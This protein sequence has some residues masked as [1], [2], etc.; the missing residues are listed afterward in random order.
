MRDSTKKPLSVKLRKSKHTMK[1]AKMA[2]KY[3]DAIAIHPRTQSQ[4]Y[5][6]VPDIE[7]A[8]R[9]KK[10]SKVPVIYSG[11][12]NL[13]NH[14]ELLK[15]FDYLMIGRKAIGN[16]DIFAELLGRKSNTN[17]NDYL[18]I[19]AKYKLPFRQ[20]KIQAMGFT[21]G[22]R[23]A[24]KLRLEIFKTRKIQDIKKLLTNRIF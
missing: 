17:F 11:D 9:L 18:T 7:F 4:G 1:I 14:E 16:P 15:T 3:C 23:D 10:R 13:D 2:E 6:G 12:V 24:T 8:K 5:G 19:A 22:L 21:K 20:I